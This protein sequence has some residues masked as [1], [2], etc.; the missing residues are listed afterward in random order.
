MDNFNKIQKCYCQYCNKECHSKN[1][2]IQHENRCKY[3]E[4]RINIKVGNNGATKGYILIHKNNSEKFVKPIELNDYLNNGWIKGHSK[5][6]L[7][8]HRIVCKNIHPTGHA[9]TKEAE[10]LRKQKISNSMKGN[11]NWMHNKIRGNGKKG[12]YHGI[13]CDS[14]W[15]LAF[16]I[17]CFE[18]NI[19][20][21]RC[22]IKYTYIFNNEKHIYIPDFITDDGI[23]EVKGRFDAKTKEKMKQFPNI[24][25][26]DKNKMK[27]IL[28]YAI[29]KYGNE[30][31]KITYDKYQSAENNI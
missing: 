30:F 14:T 27:P 6:Y 1:S 4:N 13:Y 3:N 31:W 18:H 29:Q 2:L 25:I 28:E 19:N 26:Y 11:T 12:K 7:E 22:D 17:Y 16:L 10:I 5:K 21:K 24:I 15:E 8:Y 9:K 20:V 23:I